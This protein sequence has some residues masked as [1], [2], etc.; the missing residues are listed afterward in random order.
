MP[1][2]KHGAPDGGPEE[3]ARSIGFY[4]SGFFQRAALSSSWPSA[5]T[6]TQ[7]F[8][9]TTAP[10]MKTACAPRAGNWPQRWAL[11]SGTS[12][13]NLETRPEKVVSASTGTCA[14]P[15]TNP[16]RDYIWIALPPPRRRQAHHDGMY[17]D[18]SDSGAQLRHGLLRRNRPLMNALR[19]RILTEPDRVLEMTA[20]ASTA[21]RSTPTPSAASRSRRECRNRQ[22][23]VR[24][25]GVLRG[26]EIKDF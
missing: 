16:Y 8:F 7:S 10:G 13:P 17:F 3:K 2:L 11:P 4:V 14:S 23:L 5:S 12:T 21:S 9:W 26:A 20:S 24:A 6:T 22:D 25:Q 19:R 15:K 1:A 18:I